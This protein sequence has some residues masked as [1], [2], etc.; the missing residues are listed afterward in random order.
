MVDPPLDG[1]RLGYGFVY[2]LGLSYEYNLNVP[3]AFGG[4]AYRNVID[5]P[6]H[7]ASL[8]YVWKSWT[9]QGEYRYQ[10]YNTD[11]E[12]NGNRVSST[13]VGNDTWYVGAAYRVNSWLEVGSYY[14][15]NYADVANRDGSGTAVPSDAYQ[16]DFALSL[17]FDPKP[18]WIIKVEGHAITGTALLNDD[19]NNPNR[20][21][22]EWYMLALKTTFSF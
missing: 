5:I 18:W 10:T 21:G 4:G 8:E 16:K 7:H 15:E 20:T 6:L 9:F 1:F 22:K 2:G 13:H 11:T 17:R 12:R 3:P 14:T 19:Q